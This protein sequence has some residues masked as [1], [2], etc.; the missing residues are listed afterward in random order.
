MR[1]SQGPPAS[2]TP[3]ADA[4]AV[5]RT[6]EQVG[7]DV[8]GPRA[9]QTDAGTEPPRQNFA[10]LGEAGLLGLAVPTAY[11]GLGLDSVTILQVKEILARYCGLTPF[12][13]TQHTGVCGSIASGGKPI[14]AT[15]LPLLA[16]GELLVG[17]GASQLRR[18]GEPLLRA[19]AVEGGYLLDGTVPWASGLG[20]MTHLALGAVVEGAGPLFFWVPFVP[21]PGIAFSAPMDLMVMRAARTVSVTCESLFVPGSSVLYDDR[22]GSWRVEHGGPL[23]NPVAYLLGVGAACLD[24]LGE[25]VAGSGSAAQRDRL[26]RE[27]EHLLALRERYYA[28]LRRMYEDRRDTA[29]LDALLALRVEASAH[30]LHLA[31]LAVAAEGGTAHLRANP[32]QRHLREAAFFSTVTVNASVRDAMITG[33]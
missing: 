27:R 9:E 23:S 4:Q 29:V 10:A 2:G 17:I 32:A 31:G 15:I 16:R 26:A 14:A 19:R 22:S 30:V 28:L 24:G 8:L 7:R 33:F 6:A 11:G 25:R 12:L 5:L 13:L 1:A 18:G 21:A 20:L 3:A